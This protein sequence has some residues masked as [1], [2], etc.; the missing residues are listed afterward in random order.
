[1][2]LPEWLQL[3]TT[4]NSY[5]GYHVLGGGIGGVI[6]HLLGSTNLLTLIIVLLIALWWESCEY[7]TTDIMKVYGSKRNWFFDSL[8]DVL[9]A[10]IN[11]ALVIFL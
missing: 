5:F 8:G 10:L 3:M 7:I 6:L 11:C 2:K 9:G 4:K 1:M